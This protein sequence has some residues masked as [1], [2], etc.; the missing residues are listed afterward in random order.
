[1]VSPLTGKVN[2]S[3]DISTALYVLSYN[4]EM[5]RWRQTYYD[6]RSNVPGSW[7]NDPPTDFGPAK[8]KVYLTG[9][10]EDGSSI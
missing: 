9:G 8:F 4:P 6:M 5:M 2:V 7:V 1:M 10:K 3:W